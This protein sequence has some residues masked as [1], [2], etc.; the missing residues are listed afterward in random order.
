MAKCSLGTNLQKKN[1]KRYAS[2]S[3]N[4]HHFVRLNHFIDLRD[5]NKVQDQDGQNCLKEKLLKMQRMIFV[6]T[7]EHSFEQDC[8]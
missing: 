3:H 8:V 4:H 1:P 7:V 2:S 6:H 5:Q